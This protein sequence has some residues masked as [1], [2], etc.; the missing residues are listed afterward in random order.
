MNA[1]VKPKLHSSEITQWEVY[2]AKMSKWV[3]QNWDLF[4]WSFYKLRR[5][6]IMS[7]F[8]QFYISF[9]NSMQFVARLLCIDEIKVDEKNYPGRLTFLLSSYT[10][11]DSYTYFTP[12]KVHKVN[13]SICLYVHTN[14]DVL[15]KN[16]HVIIQKDDSIFP[17]IILVLYIKSEY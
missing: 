2:T 6:S 7:T 8:F 10:S 9:F 15:I 3:F 13:V 11:F 5:Y 17:K 12:H 1:F 14:C 16:F 4:Y